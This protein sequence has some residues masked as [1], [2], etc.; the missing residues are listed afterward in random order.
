[1]KCPEG[2]VE[3][4]VWPDG[5]F[6]DSQKSQKNSTFMIT[7][8]ILDPE[9]YPDDEVLYHRVMAAL[10]PVLDLG[11]NWEVDTHKIH[12]FE[13]DVFEELTKEIHDEV[14]IRND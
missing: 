8:I 7:N 5:I 3:V 12:L 1:M 2:T 6:F 4:A 11:H 9:Y 10:K 14:P 13:P